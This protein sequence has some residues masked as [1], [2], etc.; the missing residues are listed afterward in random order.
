MPTV[1][2]PSFKGVGQK[3]GV[4]IW[5]IEQLK[6]VKKAAADKC[7]EGQFHTGDSYIILQ[8]KVGEECVVSLISWCAA[9]RVCP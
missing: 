7:Y 6:V 1:F 5:R 2:D 8:T 4:E 3:P 9:A